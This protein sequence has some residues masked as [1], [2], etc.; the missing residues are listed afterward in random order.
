MIGDYLKFCKD[1][2][3][4]IL[5]EE[6]VTVYRKQ[7]LRKGFIGADF[8]IFQEILKEIFSVKETI[9]LIK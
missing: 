5:K 2:E 7:S 4:P 8:T 1:F 6:Q 3:M 9:D